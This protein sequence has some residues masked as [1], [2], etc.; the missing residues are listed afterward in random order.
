M[1]VMRKLPSRTRDIP[2]LRPLSAFDLT[3]VKI[4]ET[5]ESLSMLGVGQG[6]WGI[7]NTLERHAERMTVSSYG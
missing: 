5:Y 4:S 7:G 6:P 1:D 2:S 3:P